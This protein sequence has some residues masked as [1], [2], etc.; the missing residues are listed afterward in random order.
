MVIVWDIV[1]AKDQKYRF[2]DSVVAY[3]FLAPAL[4]LI[5]LFVIQPIVLSL[6]YAFTDYYLLEPN[7]IHF[8]GLENFR[9]LLDDFRQKGDVYHALVNTAYFVVLV[10]PIQISVALGLALLVNKPFKGNTFFKVAFFS[11]VVMSLTVISLLWLNIL[12]PD[13]QGMLN[14]LLSVFGIPPQKFLSD[15][16]Q[17]M[18]I[19]VLV[20]A[21]QGAGFQMM[22]FLAGL[23]NISPEL[24]E[25]ASL[26]GANAWK[27]F[28][29]ITLPG[30]KPTTVFIIITTFIA[31]TKLI[32]QP[33]IMT[34]YKSYTVT[35]SYL[36]YMEGYFFKMVGY[37]SALALL[38][39]ILVGSATMLQRYLLRE[40]D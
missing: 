8:T 39:T 28:R 6:Y 15:P 13:E 14:G 20:S 33:M 18:T 17:A 29:Y 19:I 26:D 24:Y 34:G 25:A 31:A 12:R 16:D 2:R 9:S 22:I 21:W 10:V 27:K 38:V 11:P 32:I 3:L 23:K 1:R 37:A 4:V 35:L 36:I 30:I 40:E 7:N 5:V